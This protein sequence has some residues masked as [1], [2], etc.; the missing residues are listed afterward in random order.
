VNAVEAGSG[1]GM[2]L[3]GRTVVKQRK[4]MEERNSLIMQIRA[5]PGFEHYLMAPSFDTIRSAAACGPVV[6]IN[7]S[8]WRSDI[9]ILL[10]ASFRYHDD[11]AIELRDRL[12]NTRKQHCLES[13]QYQHA[14]RYVLQALY[15][16]V[17]RP[18]IGEL[19]RLNIPEQ[20]RVWWCPTSVF[21]FL[22]L[23]AM[24]PIP[25]EDATFWIY[26]SLH[27]PQHYLRSLALANPADNRWR[28]LHYFL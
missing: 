11:R 5:L 7:H 16:L 22:P 18:V 23:H 17:G 10:H 24:G 2:D 13:K 20:S 14:L 27:T 1:E 21:C 8:Q 26:T 19:R 12:V 15:E 4:L 3:F 28:S 9:L 25:S 6:I